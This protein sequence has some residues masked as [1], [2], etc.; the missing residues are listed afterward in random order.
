MKRPTQADVAR[1]AGV[2]RATVS[3][4]MNNQGE[5]R[6]PISEETRQRVLDAIAELGYEVDARA[7]SL[8]SGETKTIGVLVPMYENPFYWQI[9]LGISTEAESH[10]YSLLLAHNSLTAEQ[11]T[12]SIREL[13]EHRVDG[14]ILLMGFKQFSKSVTNQLRKSS[15]PIVEISATP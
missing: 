1:L 13:A 9:L 6:I 8:R 14:L 3:Y 15:R 4:V 2:S 7:Q 10:G 5:Q 11:E 12:Q